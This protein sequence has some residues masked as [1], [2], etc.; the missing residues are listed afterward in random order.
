MLDNFNGKWIDI[1]KAFTLL[2]RLFKILI[3]SSLLFRVS[4]YLLLF[5][6][7]YKFCKFH[8]LY[9]FSLEGNI[10]RVDMIYFQEL[11]KVYLP[12]DEEFGN[13]LQQMISFLPRRLSGALLSPLSPLDWIIHLS[14]QL[15]ALCGLL[16]LTLFD[17]I[18]LF[19]SFTKLF[20]F[21]LLFFNH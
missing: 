6:K 11:P 10:F 13:L 5:H 21:Y 15:Q 18:H 2:K 17:I 12:I 4:E 7:V 3:K 20:I 14:I 9:L 8:S 19:D 16:E 1:L